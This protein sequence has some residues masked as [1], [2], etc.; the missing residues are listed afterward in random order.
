MDTRMD[1][2]WRQS[3]WSKTTK[4]SRDALSR[5]LE[6]HGYRVLLAVDGR[7]AVSM[8]RTALPDLILMDLGLPVL[9]GWDATRQLKDD[10]ATRH[11]PIIV[12]ERACDDQRSR[13][14]ARGRRRRFRHEA[15]SVSGA[16][17]KDRDAARRNDGRLMTPPGSHPRRR[18][19]RI[20]SGRAVAA[21][22]RRKVFSSRPPRTGS[23]ALECVASGRYDLV[24]L[25]VEMPG[26]SGLE[27]LS[28]LRET[29]FADRA[30][31][32][33]GHRAGHKAPTSSKRSALART[34]TSPSRSIS[35]SRSR[36]STR[37]CR[38]NGPIADLHESEERYAVAV[39]GANDGLW[40]WNIDDQRGVL[41]AALEGAARVRRRRKSARIPMN[42]CRESITKT[43][44]A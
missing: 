25:D 43:R 1:T 39:R 31:G 41:V 27:V 21:A 20:Q 14:G 2:R 5:R 6:R 13:H 36:A 17:G 35:L 23:G 19:Q 15:D 12:L 3:W 33:H 4:P 24:L 16:A 44:S 37:I 8:A 18:R 7:Q 29:P 38:T 34:T 26:M 32:D 42:G 40:D 30:A 9:D 11:I 28:R 22:R 10:A